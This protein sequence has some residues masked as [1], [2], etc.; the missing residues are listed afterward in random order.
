MGIFPPAESPLRTPVKVK[1][2]E[3]DIS[4]QAISCHS[5]PVSK[6]FSSSDTGNGPLARGASPSWLPAA[7]LTSLCH[8]MRSTHFLSGVWG[9]FSIIISEELGEKGNRGRAAALA[10][11]LSF[12][13]CLNKI[14]SASFHNVSGR[15]F[16]L[17]QHSS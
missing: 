14:A 6:T 9:E 4:V 17:L 11:A 15:Y 2:I 12:R 8:L 5:A 16:S 1:V 10:S 13:E 3:K 7:L